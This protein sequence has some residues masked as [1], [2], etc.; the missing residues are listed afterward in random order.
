MSAM[1]IGRLHVLTDFR[2]Q[3]RHSHAA[4]ARMAIEGGA[5]TIQFR[6]KFGNIRHQIIQLE[7]VAAVCRERNVTLLVNDHI[8]L[9]LLD[10][11]NGVHLGQ[12]DFPIRLARRILGDDA[13]IGATATTTDQA[14]RA[15]DDGA[16]YIGFGPVFP[17]ASKDNPASVKGIAGLMDACRRVSIPVI[18]IAG[19]TP[20]RVPEAMTAG[21]YGVA[22]MTAVTSAADPAEATAAFKRQ[23]SAVLAAPA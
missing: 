20:E 3:Q 8:E 18:A 7:E 5:D 11:I 16:S 1:A 13:V 2:F 19:M 21:A 12:N 15:E 4:L 14:L 17:T 9:A 23:V 10:G 22:V 6:Q